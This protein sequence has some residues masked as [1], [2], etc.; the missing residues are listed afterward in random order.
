MVKRT[1]FGVLVLDGLVSLHRTFQFSFFG[2]SGWGI[3]LDYCDVEW[4]SLETNQDHSVVF[5]I[6]PK[7]CILDSFIDYEGYPFLL[8][9]YCPQ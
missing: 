4:F 7:D 2:I 9:D 8:R 6:A 1:S 5:E 3:E